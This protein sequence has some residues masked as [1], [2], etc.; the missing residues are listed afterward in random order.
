[1]KIIFFVVVAVLVIV[2]IGFLIKLPDNSQRAL[3]QVI[4]D[5]E[6]TTLGKAFK[7]RLQDYPVL[8]GVYMLRNGLDAFVARA[9]L[10]RLAERSIDVQYYMFHQDTVGRLLINELLDA[11]DRGVRIRLLVDDMYGEEADDI[12]LSLDSHPSFEVRLFNPFVRNI[13]KNIQ[14]FATV[15]RVNHWEQAYRKWAMQ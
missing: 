3:S 6:S 7:A 4:S 9:G 11:A 10:A 14:F 12:W 5:G 2:L 1:M 13:S 8:S 15:K